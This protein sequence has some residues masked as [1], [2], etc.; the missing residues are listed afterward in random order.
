VGPYDGESVIRA[1]EESV[2]V[3]GPLRVPRAMT[4][5]DDFG[6]FLISKGLKKG[7]SK[8][9]KVWVQERTR[10]KSSKCAFCLRL[11]F[12]LSGLE[13]PKSRLVCK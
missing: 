10:H 7:W 5:D 4:L 2:D 6:A 1:L 11:T 8:S 3:L 12:A 9:L 13:G